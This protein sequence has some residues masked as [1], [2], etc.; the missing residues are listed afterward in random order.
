M[1]SW[2]SKKLNTW[3]NDLQ[4]G[5]YRMAKFLDMAPATYIK[6][7][8]DGISEKQSDEIEARYHYWMRKQPLDRFHNK[9]QRGI[10][11]EL[12]L[13]RLIRRKAK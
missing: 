7:E 11:G 10:L 12:G 4:Y 1:M 9:T 5:K 13:K 6:M 3:R 2:T 8:R